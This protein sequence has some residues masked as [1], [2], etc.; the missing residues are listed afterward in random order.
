MDR[1][2]ALLVAAGVVAALGTLLVFLYV[3]GADDRASDKFDAVKVLTV[4]KQINAGETV[5]QAQDAGKI[6]VGSVGRGQ[7]LP[8]ALDSLSAVE[9]QIALTNMYPGEQVIA[10]KFGSNATSAS[11]L[12]IAK[13]HVAISVNLTDTARVAGFVNPGDKV[14]IFARDR[15][16]DA[17]R[18]LLSNV[19]VIAV[20]ATSTITRTTTDETG[21]QST[22]QLPRTL[23]T[24]SVTQ[25]SAEKILHASG[26]TVTQGGQELAFGLLNDDSVAKPGDPG[27]T[28]LNLFR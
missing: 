20:G 26:S 16:S 21:A 11:S 9:G 4:T 22:E 13:G 18:A 3:K 27:V 19:E 12:T 17:T 7:L 25:N 24:L 1:R 28:N 23:F 6:E 5:A 2:R 14:V 10:S 8:G 15:A